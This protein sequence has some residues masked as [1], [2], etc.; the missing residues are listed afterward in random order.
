MLTLSRS[1]TSEREICML[2]RE[3]EIQEREVVI[4]TPSPTSQWEI[5]M[6]EREQIQEEIRETEVHMLERE[7]ISWTFPTNLVKD[8]VAMAT[9]AREDSTLVEKVPILEKVVISARVAPHTH[10]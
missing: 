3:E 9:P 5:C 1:S 6:L 7:E 4:L 8:T 2:E 10:Q